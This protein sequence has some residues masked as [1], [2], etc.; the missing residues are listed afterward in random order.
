M[1]ESLNEFMYIYSVTC[2]TRV[3]HYSDLRGGVC[4]WLKPVAMLCYA[5]LMEW[6]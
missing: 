4:F 5:V 6:L 3:K 1:Y 2:L